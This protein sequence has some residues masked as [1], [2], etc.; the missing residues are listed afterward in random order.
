VT[1]FC[2]RR[3]FDVD[4]YVGIKEERANR[5][6]VQKEATSFRGAISLA[7]SEAQGFLRNYLFDVSPTTDDRPYFSTSFVGTRHGLFSS[8]SEKS[9]CL[10]LKSE[11][12][13]SSP[14]WYKLSLP[15]GL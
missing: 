13:S 10:S 9:F 14:L 1:A 6:D 8:S 2:D 5:Y 15:A 3:S 11:P 12:S 7:G 4:F